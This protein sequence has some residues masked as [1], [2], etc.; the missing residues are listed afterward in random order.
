MKT[1]KRMNHILK[2]SQQEVIQSEKLASVGLLAAGVAHEI[3]N[4][5][6]AIL[7]YVG[8]MQQGMDSS[9]DYTDYLKRMEREI[10]R[11]HRIVKDLREYSKPSPCEFIPEQSNEIIRDSVNL[12][13]RQPEFRSI[14]FKLELEADLMKA[15][16]ES[17]DY[18]EGVSAFL[19]KREPK[20]QGK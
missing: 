13:S 5:L 19:Q 6:G 3:G 14:H 11:I 7:G 12:V 16:G 8:I 20:F 1:L 9:K 2:E 18:A 4:P 15:C 10:L 17:A